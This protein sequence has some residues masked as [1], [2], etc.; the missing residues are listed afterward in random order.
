MKKVLAAI[1]LTLTLS[2]TL[3]AGPNP[4]VIFVSGTVTDK[5]SNETIAGVEVRVKGTDIVTYTNFDGNYFL[6]ELPAGNYTLE[7]TYITYTSASVA[8]SGTDAEPQIN[9][10]LEQR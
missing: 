5:I 3:L 2:T 9:V 1:L 6:P 10:E 8:A 4:S 7:F